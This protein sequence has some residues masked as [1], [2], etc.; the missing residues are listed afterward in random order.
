MTFQITPYVMLDGNAKEAI[1]FYEKALQAKVIRIT[2]FA[3]MPESSNFSVPPNAK[4]RISH[5]MLKVGETNLMLSDTFPGQPC[6]TGN[7]VTICITTKDAEKSKQVYD[8]LKQEGQVNMPLQETFWSPA[9]GLVTDKF[10]VTF[11]I[12]TEC[13][14]HPHS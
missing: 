3:E 1:H 8:I 4:E 13:G 10:G 11:H 12:S 9:Y 2:T 14:S 5:A 7:Q 6:Q